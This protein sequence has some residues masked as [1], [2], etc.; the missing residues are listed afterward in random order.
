MS[1]AEKTDVDQR[2]CVLIAESASNSGTPELRYCHSLRTVLGYE[3]ELVRV[4]MVSCRSLQSFQPRMRSL[5]VLDHLQPCKDVLEPI[6]DVSAIRAFECDIEVDGTGYA[7]TPKFLALKPYLESLSISGANG[8]ST[9]EMCPVLQN[10]E[11]IVSS[12]STSTSLSLK[13]LPT[14]LVHFS[15]RGYL[16]RCR[17]NYIDA[18][19]SCSSLKTLSFCG[20]TPLPNVP[21]GLL[22]ALPALCELEFVNCGDIIL[23][24]S[25]TELTAPWPMLRTLRVIGSNGNITAQHIHAIF[26]SEPSLLKIV[27]TF[28][29]LH[30]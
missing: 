8:M 12:A 27:L 18:L 24:E 3:L 29:P 5:A 17:L 23:K 14:S 16:I 10:L 25:R 4:L 15:L 30:S 7:D 20:L 19:C 13:G 1:H 21:I 2:E 11:F 22:S 9:L 6:E 28:H 26:R